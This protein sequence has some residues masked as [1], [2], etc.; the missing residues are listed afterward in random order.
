[1]LH[2]VT[3]TMN[4]T[5]T[6]KIETPDKAEQLPRTF[7]DPEGG[8][9]IAISPDESLNIQ[10]RQGEYSHRPPVWNI[11]P[12]QNDPPEP[13]DSEASPSPD[14]RAAHRDPAVAD[15]CQFCL[16]RLPDPALSPSAQIPRP[17]PALEKPPT[18]GR[19]LRKTLSFLRDRSKPSTSTIPPF[20]DSPITNQD[21]ILPRL[22]TRGRLPDGTVY[23]EGSTV[24]T[25]SDGSA[26]SRSSW[27][28]LTGFVAG[29]PSRLRASTRKRN[30]KKRSP[31]QTVAT[32][33]LGS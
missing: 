2:S 23:E 11:R 6:T 24:A 16:Q 18:M 31:Y 33:S 15:A 25:D 26:P 8:T 27:S 13:S 22:R 12:L 21:L 4:E 1:M 5:G 3:S 29:I 28:K 20:N 32:D 9:P 7:L 30:V 17:C 19:S 14:V 10:R